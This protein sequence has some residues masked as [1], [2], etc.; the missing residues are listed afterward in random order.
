M[1]LSIAPHNG[2]ALALAIPNSDTLV[3]ILIRKSMTR[4]EDIKYE[5]NLAAR[6]HRARFP[7]GNQY[8]NVISAHQHAWNHTDNRIPDKRADFWRRLETCNRGIPNRELLVMGGDLNVQVS[9]TGRLS[10][11]SPRRKRA[12]PDPGSP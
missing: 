10:A 11:K 8:V 7:V 1:T 12:V 9:C 6:I 5:C 4:G 3:M 2:S